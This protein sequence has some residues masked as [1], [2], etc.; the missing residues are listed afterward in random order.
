M[1]DAI[2]SAQRAMNQGQLELES[3][4]QNISNIHT[5]GFKRQITINGSFE[6]ALLADK[7]AIEKSMTLTHVHRQ[8][9]LD[10]TNGTFDFAIK[11]DGFFVVQLKDGYA[12]TRRGDFHLNKSGELV[13]FD[14][15]PVMG[16][17]GSIR[18]DNDQV[19]IKSDGTIYQDERAVGKLS[20]V[21]FKNPE[22]LITLGGGYFQAKEAGTELE[23]NNSQIKQGFLEQSNV[24]SV[25]EMTEMMRISREF[26]TSQRL[27][28]QADEMM[29]QAIN[30]LG[31]G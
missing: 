14:G 15:H 9:M 18:L 23:S 20:I 12:F 31:E 10:K 17:G 6:N 21:H 2:N 3:V 5:P 4:S 16:Q 27:M 13:T 8:G 19:S 22:R 28:R 26:Q 1:I 7:P 29:G 11:G 25:D 24:K 30:N